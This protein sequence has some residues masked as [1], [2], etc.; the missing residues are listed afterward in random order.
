[1]CGVVCK[2]A[3]EQ[4][5]EHFGCVCSTTNSDKKNQRDS[6][7][8][9]THNDLCFRNTLPLDP[10]Q[11]STDQGSFLSNIK[12]LD[13]LGICA[14]QDLTSFISDSYDDLCNVDCTSEI[15]S[16]A[17]S[18]F[19]PSSAEISDICL[20]VS[21]R[22]IQKSFSASSTSPSVGFVAVIPG[23]QHLYTS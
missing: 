7:R 16:T 17:I 3:P 9:R 11:L 21:L 22:S 23:H 15:L 18:S 20:K 13:E 1:M 10:F 6:R 8:E 19:A 14:A 2:M 4:E 12:I 5:E